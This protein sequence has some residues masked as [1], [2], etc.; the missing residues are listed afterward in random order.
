MVTIDV[1][2]STC[3][4]LASNR[5]IAYIHTY[6]VHYR[7]SI[8]ACQW[9]SAWS[10][11]EG[12]MPRV[13]ALI[14]MISIMSWSRCC[15][16]RDALPLE[17]QL[18]LPCMLVELPSASPPREIC[19]RP[20]ASD[21]EPSFSSLWV[22]HLTLPDWLGVLLVCNCCRCRAYSRSPWRLL[23]VARACYWVISLLG[24]VGLAC[25]RC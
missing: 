25:R 15:N 24:L 22:L 20:L 16:F 2:M 5:Q 4:K 11:V 13:D 14:M 12:V 18:A 9:D 8:L 19:S 17:D 23:A 1:L 3:V 7:Y 6:V 10:C 21:A